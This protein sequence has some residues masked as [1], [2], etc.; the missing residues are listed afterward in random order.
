MSE[1]MP[2]MK[3]DAEYRFNVTRYRGDLRVYTSG[4]VKH[5]THLKNDMIVNL[6]RFMIR[7]MFALDPG[8]SRRAMWAIIDGITNDRQNVQ[9]IEFVDMKTSRRC[10]SEASVIRA[11]IQEHRAVL[12]LANRAEKVP[13]MKRD[14]ERCY[15]PIVRYFGFLNRKLERKAEM[16]PSQKANEEPERQKAALLGKRFYV[17]P[18]CSIKSHYVIIDSRVLY[19]V[20]EEICPEFDGRKTEFTGENR[21]TYWKNIFYFKRRKVSKQRVFTGTIET[22]GV[23]MCVHCRRLKA[24]RPIVPSA[25]PVTKHEDEKEADPAT[26]NVH[27]SDFV[28]G[29]DPGNT[30]YIAGAAPKRA[31]D[32]SDGD[33]RQKDM[34]L[35]KLSRARYCRESGIMNARKKVETWNAGV[36][37]HLEAMSEVTSRGADFRTF[38]KFTK[39]RVA[40]WEAPWKEYAKPRW[41]RLRVNLYCGK[42]R[43][44][45]DFFNQL[46][47]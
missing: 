6:E 42:Q 22:D 38:L 37:E 9:E 32:G 10:L 30:M 46:S 41:A 17:A 23:S 35:F 1:W 29:V 27:E 25:S 2:G 21:E 36:N 43:A 19:G 45:A 44:T 31:E 7:A 28:V 13:D 8:L 33:L 24:D 14:E 5:L 47:A 16:E 26:Q 12:A 3:N 15:R 18:L 40:D 11:A 4:A 34:R 39:V 20:M